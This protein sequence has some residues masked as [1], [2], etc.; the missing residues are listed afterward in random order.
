MPISIVACCNFQ[1]I[2]HVSFS[3]AKNMKVEWKKGD[4][5]PGQCMG[6]KKYEGIEA[7]WFASFKAAMC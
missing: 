1:F 2:F 4:A 6:T 7:C 3:C 5:D